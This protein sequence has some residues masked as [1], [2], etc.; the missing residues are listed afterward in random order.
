MPH[1]LFPCYLFDHFLC[2]W[3]R[4]FFFCL[5]DFTFCVSCDLELV[6]G[7]R[8]SAVRDGWCP[9]SESP[10]CSRCRGWRCTDDHGI[11]SR[12]S[13]LLCSYRWILSP[14]LILRLTHAWLH[15]E[16]SRWPACFLNSC[17]SKLTRPPVLVSLSVSA[18]KGRGGALAAPSWATCCLD[19]IKSECQ[20]WHR[21]LILSAS[22]QQRVWQRREN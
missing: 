21:G 9:D 8:T 6:S 12:A 22:R 1:Y 7:E 16:E 3:S 17:L 10:G 15:T 14:Q 19:F 2:E 4:V 5:S 13:T 18:I 11:S 20:P